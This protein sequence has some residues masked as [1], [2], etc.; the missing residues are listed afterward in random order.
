MFRVTSQKPIASDE[1]VIISYPQRI[2]IQENMA[3]R[4]KAKNVFS[5]TSGLLCGRPNGLI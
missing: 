1:L 2:L 3:V 5:E 4:A